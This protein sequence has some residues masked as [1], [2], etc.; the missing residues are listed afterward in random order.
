MGLFV[1]VDIAADCSKDE[2]TERLT[3]SYVPW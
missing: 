1:M 2:S 3:R